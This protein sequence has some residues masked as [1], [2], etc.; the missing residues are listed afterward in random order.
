MNN[1]EKLVKIDII[2]RSG[3]YIYDDWAIKKLGLKIFLHAYY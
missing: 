3:K 1:K 2:I